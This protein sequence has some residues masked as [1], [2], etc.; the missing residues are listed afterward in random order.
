MCRLWGLRRIPCPHG[1]QRPRRTLSRSEGYP[2][3]LLEAMACRV[4]VVSTDCPTGPAEAKQ[5]SAT[6][7]QNGFGARGLYGFPGKMV[8][9]RG[10]PSLHTGVSTMLVAS[11]GGSGLVRRTNVSRVNPFRPTV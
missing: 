6:S 9:W 3:V 4:P 7:Q 1:P 5:A 2:H 10:P 8:V 11:S